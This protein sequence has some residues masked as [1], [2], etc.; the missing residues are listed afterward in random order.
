MVDRLAQNDNVV[1]TSPQST[2]STITTT[3]AQ[4]D[5]TT[6]GGAASQSSSTTTA[7]SVTTTRAP[8]SNILGNPARLGDSDAV[9]MFLNFN[10]FTDG[11]D[12]DTSR[13]TVSGI[14]SG[15]S[16]ATQLHI[17]YSNIFSGVGM[18]AGRKY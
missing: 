11:L 10:T 17:A 7:Q 5:T 3:Q 6:G 13:I 9:N 2:A 4:Q 15:G 16:M 8:S 18:V 12:I 14:S 1:I